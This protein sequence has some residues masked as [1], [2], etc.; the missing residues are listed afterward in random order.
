MFKGSIELKTIENV[1]DFI[2]VMGKVEA[3]ADLASV[4]QRHVVDAKSIL[5]VFSLNL[6]KPLELRIFDEEGP[7]EK[8][9]EIFK[10]FGCGIA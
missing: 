10:R 2:N 7:A 5:G 4:D 9:A 8:Y 1:K 3:E 6:T